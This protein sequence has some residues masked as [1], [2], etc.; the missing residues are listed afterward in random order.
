MYN[1][2][3]YKIRKQLAYYGYAGNL[4]VQICFSVGAAFVLLY[5]VDLDITVGTLVMLHQY[6]LSLISRFSSLSS[7]YAAYMQWVADTKTARGVYKSALTYNTQKDDM[8]IGNMIQVT[9][10]FTF[11]Q[12][13]VTIPEMNIQNGGHYAIVGPNG[14]GKSTFFA[15]I[16]KRRSLVV[17]RDYLFVS[18]IDINDIRSTDSFIHCSTGRYRWFP[19]RS[20]REN[21]TY[22]SPGDVAEDLLKSYMTMMDLTDDTIS[23]GQVQKGILI[24]AALSNKKIILLDEP[25]SAMSPDHQVAFFSTWKNIL[26]KNKTLVII[27]HS[28]PDMKDFSDIIMFN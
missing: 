13:K 18:G 5:L 25:T 26:F 3:V 2:K 6:Y 24:R 23:D 20:V 14:S 22:G 8:A 10:P 19:N 12:F 9:K 28:E 16:M 15:T 17:P 27:T 7:S 4:L 21:I 11:D 1:H